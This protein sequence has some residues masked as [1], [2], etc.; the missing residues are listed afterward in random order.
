MN[1]GKMRQLFTT[2]GCQFLI[3][4][5]DGSKSCVKLKDLRE[6]NPVDVAKYDTARGVKDEPDFSWWVPHTLR[7]LDVIVAAVS[8]RVNKCSNK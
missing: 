7:K 8:F 2:I 5:R 1:Q 6:S 3:K 4:W